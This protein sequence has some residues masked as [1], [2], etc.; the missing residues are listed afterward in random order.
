MHIIF[1]CYIS[2]QKCLASA[3]ILTHVCHHWRKA[4]HNLS[5][6]WKDLN[7]DTSPQHWQLTRSSRNFDIKLR[8]IPTQ[9]S[10]LY[11]CINIPRRS[12]G[13]AAGLISDW[14]HPRNN[15]RNLSIITS[16]ANDLH[17]L[18]D[19]CG[20]LQW[21]SL[22]HLSIRN[23]TDQCFKL[24]IPDGAYI[25]SLQ[26]LDLFGLNGLRLPRICSLELLVLSGTEQRIPLKEVAVFLSGL[27]RLRTLE[28]H[29]SPIYFTGAQLISIVSTL[30]RPKDLPCLTSVRIFGLGSSSEN[31]NHYLGH[32]LAFLSQISAV[33]SLQVETGKGLVDLT[34]A[35]RPSR[36]L[37]GFLGLHDVAFR[38]IKP[39][40]CEVRG[41]LNALACDNR[42]ILWL[43]VRKEFTLEFSPAKSH[44]ELA[45]EHV[46]FLFTT[47][48]RVRII[49]RGFRPFVPFAP[50]SRAKLT[51]ALLRPFVT[52]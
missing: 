40:R 13:Y 17:R 10:S 22:R 37:G 21:N 5:V 32:L 2:G 34:N 14:L 11:F 1:A 43:S 51:V 48:Q 35:L 23:A 8:R 31:T 50:F 9:F 26:S 6:V 24:Y 38:L 52:F 42:A 45:I 36:Q 12:P 47:E 3:L 7:L 28:L 30:L 4:A 41:L 15:L 39:N 25:G 33:S 20:L 18:I 29:G 27:P 46:K 44:P 49:Y 19:K 16:S